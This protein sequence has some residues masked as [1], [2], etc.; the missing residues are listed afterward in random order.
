MDGLD[1]DSLHGSFT[2][3]GLTNPSLAGNADFNAASNS[4]V[5]I[6]GKVSRCFFLSS[7]IDFK[8]PISEI[9]DWEAQ[10]YTLPA[11]LRKGSGAQLPVIQHRWLTLW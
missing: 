8:F 4:S 10:P 9:E 1:V 5:F 2:I 11:R 6:D 7:L 3:D